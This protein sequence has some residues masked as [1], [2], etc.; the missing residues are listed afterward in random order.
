MNIGG[1]LVHQSH[2]FAENGVA[3][4]IANLPGISSRVVHRSAAAYKS[5]GR[6]DNGQ[7]LEQ[8]SG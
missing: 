1:S 3:R 8:L 5:Q 7:C 4:A 6:K 2:F